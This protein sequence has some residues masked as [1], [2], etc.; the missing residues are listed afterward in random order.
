MHA[1]RWK[2]PT[3]DV[4]IFAD[5]MGVGGAGNHWFLEPA[6]VKPAIGSSGQHVEH[7]DE[8]IGHLVGVDR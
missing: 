3:K 8:H 5:D 1:S 6:R 2:L 4:G 7:P